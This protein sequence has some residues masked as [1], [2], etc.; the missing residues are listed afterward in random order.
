MVEVVA[1]PKQREKDPSLVA[2]GRSRLHQSHRSTLDR[3]FV[4]IFA[5]HEYLQP[6]DKLPAPCVLR[7]TPTR[8]TPAAEARL[9]CRR[10]A[11]TAAPDDCCEYL[12]KHQ[13]R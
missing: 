5:G 12:D 4:L 3:I 13:C 7:R 9:F 1:Q 8:A 11:A 10:V 6:I 2:S